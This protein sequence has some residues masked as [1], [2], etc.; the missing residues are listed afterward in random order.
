MGLVNS[1]IE[2]VR[3]FELPNGI[4]EDGQSIGMVR[5]ALVKWNSTLADKFYQVYVNGKYA[6]TTI[7][8]QQ[9]QMIVQVPT[10]FESAVRIEVFAVEAEEAGIDFSDEVDLSK[11]Q[12]GRVR[13]RL[14]RSQ[15]LPAEAVVQIYFDSGT[16]TID[17]ENPLSSL[18]LRIWPA[19]QDKAGFGMSEFGSGDFGF[20]SAAAVGFGKGVFGCE[21][22][23]IGAD[24][25]EWISG[26]L[27]CGRYKFAVKV[28]DAAGNESSSIE[29][30]EIVVTPGAKPAEQLDISSF[31][32]APNQLVLNVS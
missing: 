22:F 2:K 14:L 12:S 19:W 21:Q 31:D 25:F 5:V 23:G 18:P 4:W 8:S 28:V 1:G 30:G 9:R 27:P 3:A 15:T 13:L 17:Y 26:Q 16:G 10:S 11:W 32:K 6:G 7:D 24:M 20:D 29:T